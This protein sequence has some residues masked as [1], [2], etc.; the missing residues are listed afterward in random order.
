MI[1][2]F[3]TEHGFTLIEVM[4]ALVVLCFGLLAIAAMQDIALGRNMDANELSLG[5]NLVADMMERIRFSRQTV[6]L[7]SGIDTTNAA[8][9]PA[10]ASIT[11]CTTL[12]VSGTGNVT[13]AQCTNALPMAQGDFDQWSARLAATGLRGI[14]GSVTVGAAGPVGLGQNQITV[15]VTW[16][17]GNRTD[18]A[19]ARTRSV[20]FGTVVTLE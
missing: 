10:A 11:T 15:L 4:I 19:R 16:T 3:R 1:S 13:L 8:T 12:G 5:T 7:Y 2:N 17:G 9:R 6:G 14:R 20:S 18:T